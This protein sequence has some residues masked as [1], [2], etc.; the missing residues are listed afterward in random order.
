MFSALKRIFSIQEVEY[1]LEEYMQ[2]LEAYAMLLNQQGLNLR[3][4]AGI[5]PPRFRYA[6]SSRQ[7]RV[8]ES[9][10]L[11]IRILNKMIETKADLRDSRVFMEF[12]VKE[13]NGVVHKDLIGKISK[14]DIVEFYDRDYFQFLRSLR[15]FEV[16]TMSL[17]Q[18]YFMKWTELTTRSVLI[19]AMIFKEAAKYLL[20]NGL[21]IYEWSIPRHSMKETLEGGNELGLLLKYMS[22]VQGQ[23]GVDLCHVIVNDAEIWNKV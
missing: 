6:S 9:L 23:D 11:S 13:L 3:T 18:L 10:K 14:T 15:F 20:S 2:L 19:S 16:T 5:G 17:D 21:R 4:V 1:S 12:A 8:M 7:K 22:P